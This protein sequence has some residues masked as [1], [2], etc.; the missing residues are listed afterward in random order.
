[1][2]PRDL[3]LTLLVVTVWG[4]NFVAIRWGVDEV[5]PL[6]MTALRYLLAAVP[7]VFFVRRPAVSWPM[8]VGYGFAIGVLQFGLMF[9]AIKLGM[10]AGLSS[11]V[12]Q[13][14]VFFTMGLAVLFLAERPGPVQW[15][16]AVVAFGGIAVIGIERLQAAA[17]VPLLM[18]I[19]AAFFWGVGNIFTKKAGKVDMLGFVVWSAL[20]PPIPLLGL[21]LLFEG[22]GAIPAA[23][24]NLTWVGGGSLLFIAY[25]ATLFGYGCWSYLLSRYPA[26]VVAP[27]SLLVP[28]AGI[29]SAAL[30]LGETISG[31]EIVGSA[32]VFVGLLLNVFGPRVWARVVA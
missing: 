9:T 8:L 22:P 31:L 4:L 19:V 5:A 7:A 23:F 2:S 20:V 27:F 29:G 6:L 16:G 30:L 26:G 1:M 21:S 32:L 11:L 10:P 14:Q 24:A 25:A 3:I 12:M 18:T 17:L 15:L 13:L 28:I